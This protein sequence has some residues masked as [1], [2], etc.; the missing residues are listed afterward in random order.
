LAQRMGSLTSQ[1][2][3]QELALRSQGYV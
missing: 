2:A 1:R 3:Q